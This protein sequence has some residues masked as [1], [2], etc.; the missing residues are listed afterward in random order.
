VAL[1]SGVA[2]ACLAG[3]SAPADAAPRRMGYYQNFGGWFSSPVVPARRAHYARRGESS[4]ARGER[5]EPKKN[6]G[7]GE[8]P[9][10]P[11]QIIVNISTQKV[12]LY[13]NG[14]RVAQGPVSTGVP[15]HP[16][17]QGVF[18][19]IEKDRYHHSNI[20]SGAPMP[21]MQRIT[22][23][24]V[25]LHEG[26]LPGYPASHGCIRMS[27]DFAQ[28][29]WPVT[30]LGVR[31]IVTRHNVE[32][33]EF[34]HAKLFVPKP[35]PTEPGV[36]MNPTTDGANVR[37]AQATAPDAASDASVMADP[38]KPATEQPT[39]A[40]EPSAAAPSV[41]EPKAAEATTA[42]VE[43]VTPAADTKAA[44]AV[45]P[46]ETTDEP[47]TGAVKS[48]QPAAA[49]TVPVAP[50]DLRKSVEAPPAPVKPVEVVPAAAPAPTPANDIIKPA[51]TVD[52]A[53]PVSPRT[54]TAV[55]PA[56]P[57]GQVAVFV[58]RKEKKIYVRQG[59]T[60]LF[61]MP[62]TIDEP[63]QPLG[64]H[65]F[66]ALQV[67]NDGASMRWNL[68]SIPTDPVAMMEDRGRGRKSKE[69]P[70][71]VVQV[72]SKPT[73]TAAEALDRIQ[74]PQEAVDRI[75]ELLIPGS[76]LVISDAGTS[77]ETGRGTEFIV[78]TR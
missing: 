1:V 57:A 75:S 58:S 70:K 15:G 68:M 74:F 60:P 13:A 7:F 36:A 50:P 26:V 41:N 61:D 17:P 24:G 3:I 63:D 43:T 51:P 5:P 16:T 14:E 65:V 45:K 25:A 23:S 22:W 27:H 73:S 40:A 4:A 72:H 78:L 32:P 20:Y 66:T 30:K 18:S 56:K 71:P 38:P 19:I 48:I 47:S 44:D 64:T 35:K 8:I 54:K 11:Q 39:P 42:P 62:I 77:H 34:Q 67:T 76:S 37:L 69:L 28:K 33:A 12:T 21:F 55:Q 53:K 2:L 6:P 59:N 9:K 10:G 46:V 52:P 31:V 49:E 29:L